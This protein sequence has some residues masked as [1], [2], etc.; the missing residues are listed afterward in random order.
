MDGV[1]Q[2]S[3]DALLFKFV[4]ITEKVH[5]RF[6]IDFFNVR[7]HPNNPTSVASTGILATRNSG[8]AF[9]GPL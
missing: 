8:S 4:N 6:D 1:N 2:W 5:M 3:Q 7:N 9:L